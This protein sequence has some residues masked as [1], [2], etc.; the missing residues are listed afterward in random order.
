M[1]GSEPAAQT[2]KEGFGSIL[3]FGFDEKDQREL[4]SKSADTGV[5]M[6]LQFVADLETAKALLCMK[7]PEGWSPEVVLLEWGHKNS[8]GLE[9]IRWTRR[10]PE[11]REKI[12]TVC[13][14]NC[15]DDTVKEA[16]AEG[17]DCC[18]NKSADFEDVIRMIKR[19]ES[20][21]AMEVQSTAE[22]GC[23]P[24]ERSESSRASTA[25]TAPEKA[26]MANQA[27]I[28]LA[29]DREDDIVLIRKAFKNAFVTNPL[30]VVRDGEAVIEYLNGEGKYANRA[31]YPLPA[32]LLLDLKMPFKDGFEVLRWIRQQPGL[33]MLPVVVLTSSDNMH[34]VNAAYKAGANSFLVK[35]TEFQD[36]KA[37]TNFLTQYW[38]ELN[39]GPDTARLPR[40]QEEQK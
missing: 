20:I 35:P 37:M 10:K 14:E 18:V 23:H 40:L 24:V 5:T 21:F 6:R 7:Y 33:N 2:A 31:E 34:D 4:K 27:I 17:A 30:Q 26:S 22:P 32:L 25:Q 38:L 9:L 3:V 16:Y 19:V 11:L 29:E 1:S 13:S 28:L 36:F 15:N 8:E 12:V 39:K